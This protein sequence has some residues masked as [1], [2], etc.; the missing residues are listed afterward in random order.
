MTSEKKELKVVVLEL[1]YKIFGIESYEEMMGRIFSKDEL[2]EKEIVRKWKD[3]GWGDELRKH[4]RVKDIRSLTPKREIDMKEED[5]I[6]IMRGL[7]K[8]LGYNLLTVTDTNGK[9][10]ESTYRFFKVLI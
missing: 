9:M 8:P 1:L 10:N 4:L 2:K 6:I 5:V 7:L 3:G